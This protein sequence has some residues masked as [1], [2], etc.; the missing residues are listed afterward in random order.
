MCKK[1]VFFALARRIYSSFKPPAFIRCGCFASQL[2][3]GYPTDE[4]AVLLLSYKYPYS[5]LYVSALVV[6]AHQWRRGSHSYYYRQNE[7]I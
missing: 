7:I 6:F 2:S 5:G 4:S 1:G 3:I